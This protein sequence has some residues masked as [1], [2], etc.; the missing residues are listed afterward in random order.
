[1]L[2]LICPALVARGAISG[3]DATLT[4]GK[5]KWSHSSPARSWRDGETLP[6]FPLYSLH[7]RAPSPWRWLWAALA[8]A[9][10]ASCE[11]MGGTEQANMSRPLACCKKYEGLLSHLAGAVKR[12]AASPDDVDDVE[13]NT[14]WQT[15]P[16]CFVHRGRAVVEGLIYTLWEQ[17]SLNVWDRKLTKELTLS[18]GVIHGDPKL[19]ELCGESVNAGAADWLKAVCVQRSGSHDHYYWDR[20]S[21]QKLQSKFSQA[22]KN[23]SIATDP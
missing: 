12:S 16:Y 5:R 11:Q 2:L 1:M 4:E 7:A 9:T 23:V 18:A 10:V 17:R 21:F 3:R 6:C 19:S 15:I 8:A 13:I 14:L 20:S 22:P